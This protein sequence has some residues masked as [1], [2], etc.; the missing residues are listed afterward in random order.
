M[1][2]APNGLRGRQYV[3]PGH[4]RIDL[5]T[6]DAETNDLVVI[7]LKKDESHENVVGQIAMYM[8]WVRENLAKENQKVVG[9]ICVFSASPKLGLA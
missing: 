9:I 7:E 4:G 6:E 1:Y 2:Q 3:I 8:T 5:L